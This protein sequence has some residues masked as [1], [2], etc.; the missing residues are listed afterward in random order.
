[1]ASIDNV[2]SGDTL[3]AADIEGKEPTVIIESVEPKEFKSREGRMQGKLVIKFRG[4][5]KALVCNKTNAQRIAHAHGKDYDKWIGKQ[6]TLFVDPYVEFG[7]ELIP[8]IRVKVLPT[9]PTKPRDL[10]PMPD[11]TVAPDRIHNGLSDDIPF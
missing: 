2:F 3:K 6:I 5:K 1:M 9:T 7:G 8:A 11:Q 10:D 4:A